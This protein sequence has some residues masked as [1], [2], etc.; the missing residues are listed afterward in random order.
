ML[1][2]VPSVRQTVWPRH[3]ILVWYRIV[4]QGKPAMLA[5]PIVVKNLQVLVKNKLGVWTKA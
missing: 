4:K 3:V 2:T 1:R 5:V